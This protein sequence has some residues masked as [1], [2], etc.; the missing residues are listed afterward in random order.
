MG[1]KQAV[2]YL[3]EAEK[4]AAAPTGAGS[5]RDETRRRGCSYFSTAQ[6]QTGLLCLIAVGYKNIEVLLQR[7][8][9]NNSKHACVCVFAYLCVDP[10]YV[11]D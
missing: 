11:R 6:G 10:Y 4:P 8:L 2:F 3:K 9:R 1:S 5:R 7:G